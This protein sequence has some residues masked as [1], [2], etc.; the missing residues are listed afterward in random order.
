MAKFWIEGERRIAGNMRIHGAKNAALP[1]LAASLLCPDALIANCPEL[2]DVAAAGEILRHLGCTVHREGESLRIL[3][4]NASYS[5]LPAERVREMRSSILFLG[6]ILA[7]FGK[8]R[9]SFPG[10]CELGARPI[11]MHIAGLRKLGAEIL[12]DH[13]YL[14]CRVR[15]CLCGCPIALPFPSVGATENIMLAACRAWADDCQQRGARA[16]DR[17]SRR[18]PQCVRRENQHRRRRRDY[19]RRAQTARGP[20]PRHSR[21]HR[22]GNISLRGG[23]HAGR[24]SARGRLPEAS[25]RGA[26]GI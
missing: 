7:R 12:E 2:S 11:D 6:V 1:I 19:R 13:G 3:T 14:D 10:G 5:A 23:G 21:P 8:A 24:R 26:A 22:S 20:A 17:G 9:V 4:Q 18:F 16:G 15:G 25:G